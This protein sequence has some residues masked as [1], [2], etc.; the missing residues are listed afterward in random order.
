[1]G[2][3]KPGADPGTVGQAATLSDRLVGGLSGEGPKLAALV[4]DGWSGPAAGKAAGEAGTLGKLV[5]GFCD[6]TSRAAGVMRQ[7]A[8]D[9]TQL[10]ATFDRLDS[11]HTATQQ[12]IA[13]LDRE[14]AAYQGGAL[15]PPEHN[16]LQQLIAQR[17]TERGHLSSLETQHRST[18]TEFT[19]AQQRAAG[20]LAAVTPQGLTGSPAAQAAQVKAQVFQ[21]LPSVQEEEGR[22]LGQQIKDDLAK[23]GAASQ[24]DID[25][26]AANSG[27]P[28]FVKGM[29][30]TLGPAGVAALSRQ[31]KL[32]MGSPYDEDH[33]GGKKLYDALRTSFGAAA[34]QG[35][36]T[37][38]WL[39]KFDPKNALPRDLY[40]DDTGGF[41]ADLLIP[42][43][44]GQKLPTDVMK[45]VGD[46][47][48]ADLKS[49][50]DSGGPQIFDKWGAY[51]GDDSGKGPYDKNLMREFLGDLSKDPEASNGT[52]MGNFDTLQRIGRG[53][54]PGEVSHQ[55]GGDLNKVVDAGVL[56]IADLDH[57]GH[58]DTGPG[59]Q[60]FLGDALMSR[61]VLDTADHKDAHYADF[62]RGEIGS[63]ATNPRYFNDA[64]Y[65]V[66][67]IPQGG[68][69]GTSADWI[70]SDSRPWRDGTELDQSAWAAL[71]QEVMADPG[72]AAK[73]IKMTHDSMANAS[74]DLSSMVPPGGHGADPSLQYTSAIARN[75]MQHFLVNNLDGAQ[76]RLQD[77]LNTI[78]G[79]E[80]T[81]KGAAT[82]IIGWATDPDSI[83]KDLKGTTI[84]KSTDWLIHQ[85]YA[86]DQQNVQGALDGLHHQRDVLQA[87]RYNS[88]PQIYQ[89][90]AN[91]LTAKPGQIEPVQV[92]ENGHT[93]TYTGDPHQYIDKYSQTQYGE[94]GPVKHDA[95][96]LGADGRPLPVD[97]IEADPDKLRAYEEWLHDPAVQHQT[98]RA[99][100][101]TIGADHN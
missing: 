45:R 98:R 37:D 43:M 8:S 20:G 15:S 1:M 46:R 92:T 96:F 89:D 10:K 99:V 9:Y 3:W 21:G 77:Q 71:H 88:S 34:K 85:A 16:R 59:A 33:A 74:A 32:A 61:I 100:E 44:A 26:L 56:G 50:M 91:G 67:T 84:D 62:Y 4:P 57:D 39:N 2:L 68:M 69:P 86:G 41:R 95:N 81:A 66:T 93:T 40:R 47:A 31:A 22:R 24:A 18:M 53:G 30:D 87:D 19:A 83:V 54:L 73:L 27:N 70:N 5:T 78:A 94:Y 79:N 51:V 64:M 80:A 17:D 101:A 90:S 6:S 42:L 35:L 63:L 55:I 13:G 49:G 38:D 7:F 60:G 23:K 82:K 11:D 58:R 29:Y 97:Q 36:I 25:A 76:G 52:L 75:Q 72:T 14:I 48:M 28:D 65:S 12:R